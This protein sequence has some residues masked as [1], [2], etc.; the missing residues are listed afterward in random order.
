MEPGNAV[1]PPIGWDTRSR[2]Q[3]FRFVP[4]VFSL[5]FPGFPVKKR[6]KRSDSPPRF[7]WEARKSR[8]EARP[9][10]YKRARHSR[11]VQNQ[12]L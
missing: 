9:A 10:A 8:R 6:C 5:F 1:P 12:C 2:Q 4:G 11:V 7:P 3:E